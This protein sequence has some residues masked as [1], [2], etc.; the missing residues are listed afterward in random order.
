[1]PRVHT[2]RANKNYPDI[3]V[4]KGETYYKW[5]KRYGPTQRSKTYPSPSQ[6]SNAKYAAIH[7]AIKDAEKT[8]GSC[9]EPD[10][11]K[12]AL[13]EVASVARDVAGEYEESASNVESAFPNGS[14]VID[15][16]NEKKDACESFAD[17][18]ESWEPDPDNV[19][20][21]DFRQTEEYVNAKAEFESDDAQQGEVQNC[22]HCDTAIVRKGTEWL[23]LNTD[24]PPCEKHAPDFDQTEDFSSA[25][26][27]WKDEQVD[28]LRD[29]ALEALGNFGL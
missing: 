16:L 3:G 11:I 7:D 9:S 6:L 18:L 23:P 26:E 5:K 14:S 4:V 29:S 25:Y 17:E 15:D 10:D 8:I 28:G 1:M 20:E 12:S 27:S 22:E 21:D 19:D 2:L 13:E 24:A